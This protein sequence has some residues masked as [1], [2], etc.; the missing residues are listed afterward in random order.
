MTDVVAPAV[1]VWDVA[2]ITAAALAVLRLDSADTDA[3]RVGDAAVQA[4]EQIDQFL[5]QTV[6]LDATAVQS[7]FGG[8]VDL[9]VSLYR[10]KDAGTGLAASYTPG[11]TAAVD[12]DPLAKVA[13]MVLAWKDRWGIG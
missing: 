8:A 4:T 13:L 11:G 6:P 3:A 7:L 9:T 1:N 10:R 12:T 2:A 5:D